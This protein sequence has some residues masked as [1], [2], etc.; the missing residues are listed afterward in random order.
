MKSAN[1]TQHLPNY[2][3][4]ILRPEVGTKLPGAIKFHVDGQEIKDVEIIQC[5]QR[6]GDRR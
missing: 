1:A 3:R 2:N 6:R 4:E 5:H